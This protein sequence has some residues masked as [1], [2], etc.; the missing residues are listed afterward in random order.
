MNARTMPWTLLALI[1][2]LLS[3]H[4][5]AEIFHLYWIF[6][7]FD[8]LTH[9]I[10][11]VWIGH[12]TLW[13]LYGSVYMRPREWSAKQAFKY[14]LLAILC[15][16]IAWELY[17]VLVHLIQYIPFE[18]GY[19]VDTVTDVVMDTLGSITSYLYYRH[20]FMKRV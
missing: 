2:L 1:Y 14:V 20:A 8:I 12:A 6:P 10:G 19:V 4:V 13:L 11:G 9:F 5:A 17:E 16:G 15:I 18:R 3:L 7:W